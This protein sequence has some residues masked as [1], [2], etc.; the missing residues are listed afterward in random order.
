MPTLIARLVAIP[1]MQEERPYP[2]LLDR[3]GAT[4]A[5]FPAEAGRVTVMALDN[6]RVT[7]IDYRDSL[8]GIR[9]AVAKIR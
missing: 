2:T 9:E 8:A 3:D 5:F 1:K 7:A 6:L 4:T